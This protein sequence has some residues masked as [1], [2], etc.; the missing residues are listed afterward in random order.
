C[1]N[2]N[3]S[4]EDAFRSL[5]WSVEFDTGFEEDQIDD[6][7]SYKETI[8]P[9]KVFAAPLTSMGYGQSNE[10]VDAA[11]Q[12]GQHVAQSQ[13][14]A[15]NQANAPQPQPPLQS[16]ASATGE[17]LA[18]KVE[19]QMGISETNEEQLEHDLTATADVPPIAIEL[20]KTQDPDDD[21]DDK[22]SRKRLADLMP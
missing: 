22:K 11:L 19:A 17:H 1:Q 12:S 5:G 14:P 4:V 15:H 20:T 6:D 3:C 2:R 8:P 13:A 7:N 16:K 18:Y 10:A 21:D 9:N